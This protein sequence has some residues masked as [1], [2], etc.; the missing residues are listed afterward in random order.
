MIEID[1]RR[2]L[3]CLSCV[4]NCPLVAI[5]YDKLKKKMIINTKKCAECGFCID[6]CPRLVIKQVKKN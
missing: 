6:S 5:K 4:D 2:C 3:L 1:E